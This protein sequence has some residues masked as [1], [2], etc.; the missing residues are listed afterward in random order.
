MQHFWA[1]DHKPPNSVLCCAGNRL[2]QWGLGM[3]AFQMMDTMQ[4]ST[5]VYFSKAL[6]ANWTLI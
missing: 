6:P 4:G 3:V 2:D 1:P 5:N